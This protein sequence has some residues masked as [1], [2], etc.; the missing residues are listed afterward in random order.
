[1]GNALQIRGIEGD[2]AEVLQVLANA[3]AER[4]EIYRDRLKGLGLEQPKKLVGQ[5]I[6]AWQHHYRYHDGCSGCQPP[7]LEVLRLSRLDS[8]QATTR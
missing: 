8:A 4:L 1:M 2:L 6:G 5:C 3:V 7:P